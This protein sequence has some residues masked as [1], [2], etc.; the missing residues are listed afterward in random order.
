MTARTKVGSVTNVRY[1]DKKKFEA[2][3]KPFMW[4][5][6]AQQL[7][8][9]AL[10][11]VPHMLTMVHRITARIQAGMDEDFDALRDEAEVHYQFFLLAAFAL[12]N[13][14]KGL[15]VNLHPGALSGGRL[16][17]FLGTHDLLA[18]AKRAGV[19]LDTQEQDFCVMATSASTKWGRY[20]I[21]HTAAESVSSWTANLPTAV[22]VFDRLHR[23]LTKECL[24]GIEPARSPIPI[25]VVEPPA[26]PPLVSRP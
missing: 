19:T 26:P 17:R 10:L 25:P 22:E 12:E 2:M 8:C 18:L 21:A 15:I 20:P 24:G 13:S 3:G 11:L 7:H 4:G 14:L 5:H 16:P 1:T 23:R 6:K 9:A